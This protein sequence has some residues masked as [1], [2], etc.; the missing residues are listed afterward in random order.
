MKT[1]PDRIS[2]VSANFGHAPA[3]PVTLLRATFFPS[4]KCHCSLGHEPRWRRS[5]DKSRIGFSHPGEN[6]SHRRPS[7]I[8]CITRTALPFKDAFPARDS[9]IGFFRGL[10]IR[11]FPSPCFSHNGRRGSRCYPMSGIG[12]CQCRTAPPPKKA[13]DVSGGSHI[14]IM[15]FFVA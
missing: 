13:K 6:R 7:F 5:K 12:G 3:S 8:E 4:L 2:L 11:E 10:R 14:M 1:P 15:W 9:T